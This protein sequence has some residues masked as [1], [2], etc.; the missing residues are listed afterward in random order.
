[1]ERDRRAACIRIYVIFNRICQTYGLDTRGSAVRDRLFRR[2]P[3][4]LVPGSA[5]AR[6]YFRW[7][8]L[9]AASGCFFLRV[10]LAAH[11]L[12]AFEDLSVLIVWIHTCPQ[13]CERQNS[14][15]WTKAGTGL[16]ATHVVKLRTHNRPFIRW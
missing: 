13:S 1:M 4:D 8:T 12:S 11:W 6:L 16:A 14:A 5:M 10:L 2:I 15:W 9:R 3:D 7:W